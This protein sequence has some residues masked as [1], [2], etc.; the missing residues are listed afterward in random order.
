M[1][2]VIRLS[3]L[4][5]YTDEIEISYFAESNGEYRFQLQIV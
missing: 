1:E 2:I 5:D 4:F 3:F